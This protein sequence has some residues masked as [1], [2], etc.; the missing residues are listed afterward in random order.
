MFF[1]HIHFFVEFAFI[2]AATAW[3]YDRQR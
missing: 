1:L 3:P 2:L